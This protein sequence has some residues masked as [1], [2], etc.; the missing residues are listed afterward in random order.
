MPQCCF[1]CS[2]IRIEWESGHACV[3]H[4]YTTIY[5]KSKSRA[6]MRVLVTINIEFVW[7]KYVH[8]YTNIHTCYM[9]SCTHM[10]L[11]YYCLCWD[12]ICSEFTYGIRN[13]DIYTYIVLYLLIWCIFHVQF[14]ISML[15]LHPTLLLRMYVYVYIHMRILTSEA[16]FISAASADIY[17]GVEVVSLIYIVVGV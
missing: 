7:W 3:H 17:V 2:R 1:I 12:N 14:H 6:M 11:V 15:P 9:Y 5:L 13:V 8:M 10:C 4:I 16:I